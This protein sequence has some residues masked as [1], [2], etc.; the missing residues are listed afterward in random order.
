MK[1]EELIRK[2]NN[3]AGRVTTCPLCIKLDLEL[4]GWLDSKPNKG[5]F[6]NQLLAKA[7]KQ[8]EDLAEAMDELPY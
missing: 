1:K 7:K 4:K 6:I 3:R 8:E 2:G 5:R